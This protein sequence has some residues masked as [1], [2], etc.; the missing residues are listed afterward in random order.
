MPE[1]RFQIQWPDGTQETCYSPSLVVKKFLEPG[2][3]YP[4]A[5]FVER[6]RTA[7]QEGSNRVQAKFGYPCS[8][9]LGQLQRIETTAIQYAEDTAATVKLLQFIE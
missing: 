4:L 8:L 7:L 3:E 6:S 1:I 5:D 2:T 9:A